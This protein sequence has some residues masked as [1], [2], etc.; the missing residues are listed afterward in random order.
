MKRTIFSLLL[1]AALASAAD[2]KEKLPVIT[3]EQQRDFV[4][5]QNAYERAAAAFEAGLTA[6]QKKFVQDLGTANQALQQMQQALANACG[7]KQQLAADQQGFPTCVPKP[8]PEP[9]KK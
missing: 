9:T 2:D 8:A 5:A 1:V 4:V 6:A 3:A 7:A